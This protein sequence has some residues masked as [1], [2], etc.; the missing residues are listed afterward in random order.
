MASA[1][2]S[3]VL[4][5]LKRITESKKPKS[6][7]K[8]P[9]AGRPLVRESWQTNELLNKLN[10]KKPVSATPKVKTYIASNEIKGLARDASAPNVLKSL[11]VTSLDKQE[12]SIM[13]LVQHSP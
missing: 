4:D 3:V 12:M 13:D 11:L 5:A 7:S 6:V 2:E 10:S 9:P 8:L 1:D